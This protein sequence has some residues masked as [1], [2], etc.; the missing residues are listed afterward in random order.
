MRILFIA[1][2]VA[3]AVNYKSVTFC[4]EKWNVGEQQLAR[5]E[6]IFS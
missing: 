3:L 1:F 6:I 5:A 4:G 2:N